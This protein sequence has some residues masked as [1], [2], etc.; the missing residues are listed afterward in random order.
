[1]IAF[2]FDRAKMRRRL[3]IYSV[4]LVGGL[5]LVALSG[6]W[7][8]SHIAGLGWTRIIIF[9]LMITTLVRL[10]DYAR[11][12]GAFGRGVRRKGPAIVINEVGVV[13]NASDIAPGQLAWGEIEKI[14]PCDWNSRLLVDRW[15]KM[16]VISKQRG[17]TVI[18]KDGVDFQHL[19]LKRPKIIRLLSKE[20]Y[21]SGRGRWLFIPETMLTVT[22]DELMRQLN[23][24]YVAEVR[25]A[26]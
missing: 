6:G 9:V 12:V 20:W 15:T 21:A 26:A 18:L 8:L 11:W 7:A 23:S 16:P 19:L 2:D 3:I 17:V 10:I 22:A 25:G 4:I 13:D 24:F 1:M 14:Y 5:L